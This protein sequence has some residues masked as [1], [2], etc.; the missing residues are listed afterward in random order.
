MPSWR[1]NHERIVTSTGLCC[2][3]GNSV[4]RTRIQQFL[5]DNGIKEQDFTE[6]FLRRA[7]G[8]SITD[9]NEHQWLKAT[10]WRFTN[11]EH[12]V[13]QRARARKRKLGEL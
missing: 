11:L 12:V 9:V 5:H 13:D 10:A 3:K 1:W 6:T 8:F 7:C 4:S 2:S